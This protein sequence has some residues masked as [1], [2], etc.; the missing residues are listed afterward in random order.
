MKNPLPLLI[1]A[2]FLLL[3]ATACS[4]QSQYGFNRNKNGFNLDG[5][6]IPKDQI[7]RGGPAKDG[8][9]AIDDP[10]FVA[11]EAGSLQN[12]DAVLGMD[13]R[14][15]AKA[16]PVN[17]LNWHEI[18]NDRFNGEPVVITFCPLC[19]SGVA[20]SAV[21]DGTPHTF[22]V[23]GLLYNSDVLLYDRQTQSLWSQLMSQAI[24]GPHKGEH[25]QSLPITHT[26]WQD[27]QTRHPDTL[28]LSTET[29]FRRDYRASPYADYIKSPQLMFPVNKLSRRYHP[30]ELV[31]GIEIDGIF[32]AYPFVELEKTGGRLEDAVNAQPVSVHYDSRHRSAS[33]F[34]RNGKLLPGVRTFWFAWYAF[35][36][37]TEVFTGK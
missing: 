15:V 21:I 29:G 17:I 36:P 1:M 26:T 12:D 6:L 31:L 5:A 7:F 34:D 10:K 30:K 3:G 18:V 16:Y 28:V 32:K 11:A 22:G 19:G 35:H 9:P 33:A 8:F 27:W 25:L 2:A 23:S 24:S 4:A 37:D 20:Y 14:G 13:Y